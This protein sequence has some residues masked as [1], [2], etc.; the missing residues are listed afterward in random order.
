MD[1]QSSNSNIYQ[2]ESQRDYILRFLKEKEA[3][4]VSNP[5]SNPQEHI[6]RQRELQQLRDVLYSPTNTKL[7]SNFLKTLVIE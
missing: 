2:Q 6:E 7:V 3:E 5:S 1:N 4:I